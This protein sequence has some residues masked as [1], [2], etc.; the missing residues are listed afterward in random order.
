MSQ[1]SLIQTRICNVPSK[2]VKINIP[3][4]QVE[5]SCVT[6]QDLHT[7]RTAAC[8]CLW[9]RPR[10]L[11]QMRNL[12][13]NDRI[14]TKTKLLYLFIFSMLLIRRHLAFWWV[15]NRTEPEGKPTI[16]HST[17]THLSPYTSIR[18][19][20]ELDLISRTALVRGSWVILLR[21]QANHYA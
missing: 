8:R 10:H 5:D 19:K 2:G 7:P 16:I 1:D 4:A 6:W 11:R 18:G 15:G 13:N 20:Q 17:I 9:N 21:C 14:S 12:H 3:V